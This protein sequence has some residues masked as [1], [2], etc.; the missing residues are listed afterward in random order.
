MAEQ[1]EILKDTLA[2][3]QGGNEQTDDILLIG[4]F[5]LDIRFFAASIPSPVFWENVKATWEESVGPNFSTI[6]SRLIM[7]HLAIYNY[8]LWGA[9]L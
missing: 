7:S 6:S 9:T 2:E 4:S 8:F 3:W 1:K 5:A